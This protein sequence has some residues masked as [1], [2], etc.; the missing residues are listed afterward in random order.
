MRRKSAFP[1][2]IGG[3][4]NKVLNGWASA[5]K[6][7]EEKGYPLTVDEAVDRLLNELEVIDK[8]NLKTMK[9]EDLVDLHF[10]LGLYIRNQYGLNDRNYK[11]QMDTVTF[12]PDDASGVILE[13][14]WDRLNKEDPDAIHK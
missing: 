4:I 11:L 12:M 1:E 2:G 3:I 14:A 6:N 10:S 9:K 7:T 13:A 5:A 8:G